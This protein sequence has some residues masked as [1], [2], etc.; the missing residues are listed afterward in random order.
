MDFAEADRLFRHLREQH[1][2]GMLSDDIFEAEVGQ[3]KVGDENGCQW[4]IGIRSGNWYYLDDSSEWKS[5][6]PL[7]REGDD[8]RCLQC[9]RSL[10]LGEGICEECIAKAVAQTQ[11][12]E[13]HRGLENERDRAFRYRDGVTHLAITVLGLVMVCAFLFSLQA[14]ASQWVSP[15]DVTGPAVLPA[16]PTGVESRPTAAW[17]RPSLTLQAVPLPATAISQAWAPPTMGQT[18]SPTPAPESAL[19]TSLPVPSPAVI[20]PRAVPPSGSLFYSLFDESLGTFNLYTSR[21][22]EESEP[23]LLVKEA[24]QPHVNVRGQLAYRSWHSSSRGI[25]MSTLG[26]ENSR[27]LVSYSEAARP[28]WS[29][30]GNLLLFYSLQESDRKSRIYR[31]T[32]AGDFEV[33][34]WGD[35][36]IFGEVPAWLPDGR[37]AT[38]ACEEGRCGLYVMGFDRAKP[39]QLTFDTSDSAPEASSDGRHI[40]FMS[41]RDG[42]WD[43]YTV[44][45]DGQNLVRLTSNQDNDG[46]PA[47]SPDG[48][49]VAF[50]SDRDKEWAIWVTKPDGTEQH[51]L[52][53]L[54]GSIDGRVRS[55][56]SYESRGWLDERICWIP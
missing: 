40:A 9:G 56:Q 29:A 18:V 14:T 16:G 21:I 33:V 20:A 41:H 30:D 13:T 36:T 1:Q 17:P 51:R 22:G 42:N 4:M 31:A 27:R 37:F 7:V 15:A 5:G 3:I 28:S 48:R 55:A 12:N 45:V 34:K 35:A 52:L 47:W 19:P 24:S 6:D 39:F 49:Y 2:R 50:V 38:K 46:L 11:S 25:T 10:E 23:R 43:V 8:V 54:R 53:Q 32:S 44:D 26:G